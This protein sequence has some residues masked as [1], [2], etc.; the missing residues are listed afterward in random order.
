MKSLNTD[1]EH[2]ENMQRRTGLPNHKR[3]LA[4]AAQS[5]SRN[6]KCFAKFSGMV[7]LDVFRVRIEN[8]LS[9]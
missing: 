3:N 9:E 1:D 2:W 7:V 5:Y 6:L 8:K 4:S